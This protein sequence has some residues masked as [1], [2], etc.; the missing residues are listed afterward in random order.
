MS[1]IDGSAIIVFFFRADALYQ[2]DAVPVRARQP[3][4]SEESPGDRQRGGRVAARTHKGERGDEETRQRGAN[5][6]ERR[7]WAGEEENGDRRRTDA[8]CFCCSR[9]TRRRGPLTW[10]EAAR[11]APTSPRRLQEQR[12]GARQPDPNPR[13]SATCRGEYYLWCA[14][15]RRSP[16]ISDSGSTAGRSRRAA[17]CRRRSCAT[18][19][20]PDCGAAHL[21]STAQLRVPNERA[22]R[23][24]LA[25]LLCAVQRCFGSDGDSGASCRVG[26]R[27]ATSR[28]ATR[29]LLF[30]HGSLGRENATPGGRAALRGKRL[31]RARTRGRERR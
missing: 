1:L 29:G 15:G 7:Q 5:E 24:S 22:W 10:P 20:R 18:R 4:T 21:C 8:R 11:P 26:G 30:F 23:H 28:A 3:S 17:C 16:R 6:M 2:C 14:V 31:R 19:W 25:A 9:A 13:G 27:S 12:C